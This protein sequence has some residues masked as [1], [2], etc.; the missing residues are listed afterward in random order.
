MVG[1][2]ILMADTPSPS[3]CQHHHGVRGASWSRKCDPRRCVCA[4]AHTARRRPHAPA[5]RGRAARFVLGAV[6]A[7]TT[8]R[9][10]TIAHSLPCRCCQ[11]WWP[12]C[13][14]PV[15]WSPVRGC[16]SK[17]DAGRSSISFYNAFEAF[18]CWAHGLVPSARVHSNTSHLNNTLN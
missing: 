1:I 16:L 17:P 3:Q 11:Q 4:P 12:H 13:A 18:C 8:H 15:G 14:V 10:C 5:P 9:A 2:A 7:C 6:A